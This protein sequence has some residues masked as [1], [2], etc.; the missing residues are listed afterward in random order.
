MCHQGAERDRRVDDRVGELCGVFPRTRR[1]TATRRESTPRGISNTRVATADIDHMI[2]YLLV[3][4]GKYTL[5]RKLCF[6][7]TRER[8]GELV[9]R[10]RDCLTPNLQGRAGC[11]RAVERPCPPSSLFLEFSAGPASNAV[12]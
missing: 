9:I 12:D 3:S 2:S 1:C 6:D 5:V 8:L 7:L 11:F 4:I 10:E